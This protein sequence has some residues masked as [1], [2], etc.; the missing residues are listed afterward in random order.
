[1]NCREF[2]QVVTGLAAGQLMEAEARARGLAH[3]TECPLCSRRLQDEQ[4][5]SAGLRAFAASTANAEAPARLKQTLRAAFDEQAKPTVLSVV[6][7][8]VRAPA[9]PRWVLAAAAAVLVAFGIA[10]LLW[11][12]G[13]SSQPEQ[14]IAGP[15]SSPTPAVTPA[16]IA[17]PP[18][19]DKVIAKRNAPKPANKLKRFMPPAPQPEQTPTRAGETE[20]A[21]QFIPLNYARSASQDG[22]VVRVEVS[23]ASLIAMGLPLDAARAAGNVKADLKVG[24]NGVPLAIR[25]LQ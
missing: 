14:N 2:E 15:A 8:P 5:L 22:L 3:A 11:L 12:R 19:S 13:A 10:A 17:P 9:W 4:V 20:V 25:L 7:F 24:M 18:Q 1:M 6:P 21:A 23:R 16:P